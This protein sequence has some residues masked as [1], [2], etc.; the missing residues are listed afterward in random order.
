MNNLVQILLGSI[1]V[2][3]ATILLL[4]WRKRKVLPLIFLGVQI[5]FSVVMCFVFKNATEPIS[6][7][8]AV[9]IYQ[10]YSAVVNEKPNEALELLN[11]SSV[12]TADKMAYTLIK[13]RVYA[14]QGKWEEARILYEKVGKVDDSL[15]QKEE[16]DFVENLTNRKFLTA[17]E[18]SYNVTNANYL[19]SQGQDPEEY[20]FTLFTDE[21][22]QENI[23]YLDKFQKEIVPEIISSE[24]MTMSDDY[25]ILA[26]IDDID[27]LSDMAMAY[28]YK[29]YIGIGTSSFAE[30]DPQLD[31]SDNS[32][33]RKYY[34]KIYNE[35]SE[36]KEKYP[37][38]FVENQ[39]LEAYVMATVRSGNELDDL[40]ED[41]NTN[42]SQT[43]I[44]MYLSGIVN[45][46]NFSEEFAEEYAQ[47]Y[48]AVIDRLHEIEDSLEDEDEDIFIDGK[49]VSDAVEMI[50]DKD[51][52][53]FIKIC[54]ELEHKVENDEVELDKRSDTYLTLAVVENVNG[55]A[56][57]SV[58][59][60]NEAVNS[61]SE[62]SNSS[63][64]NIMSTVEETY[65]DGVS[66]MNY[67]DISNAV[68]EAY[69]S[70]HHYDVVTDEITEN[71]KSTAGTAVSQTLAL[72]SIGRIDT[73]N[74]PQINVSVVYSDDGSLKD[75]GLSMKDCN[76][77]IE[78]YT[79]EKVEHSGSKVVLMCDVSGSMAN[80]I[81][82]LQN[83]VTKYVNNM[84]SGEKVCIV[85][86]DTQVVANS[87]FTS[88]KSK[89]IQFAE[90]EIQQRGGTGVAYSAETALDMFELNDVANT[91][92]IMTDGEDNMPYSDAEIRE[93]LGGKADKNGVTIYTIG[94]GES[95]K[96]T[97]LQTIADAGSG[98]FI[99]C[100]DES[101]LQSAYEFIHMRTNSEYM[102]SFEA[103]DL[104]ST[105]RKYEIEVLDDTSATHPRDSK[106][107]SL[108]GEVEEDDTDVDFDTVL[109]DGVTISGLDINQID[110][111]D[112]AQ[113]I[114]ILGAGFDNVNVQ[115][116]Y[117]SSTEGESNC[118]IKGTEDGKITF[119]VAPSVKEGT[120]SVF[121][122]MNDT[123]YKVDKLVVGSSNPG[124]IVFGAYHFKADNIQAETDKVILSG[125]VSLNDYLYFS[126]N[127]E[128]YG[129]IDKA[130]SI[131]LYSYSSAYVRHDTANYS[132]FDKIILPKTT[133]TKA[134][135]TIKV[136]IFDDANHYNDYEEYETA[137][138]WE[139][140]IAS[141]N[142]GIVSFED[143]QTR[144]YP[145]RV[146]IHSGIGVLKDNTITDL[147]TNG[148]EF[149]QMPDGMPYIKGELDSDS[150]LMK[151]GPFTYF[152]MDIEAGI[153]DEENKC[154]I[155][156]VDYISVE[157][158]AGFKLMYDTYKREFLLG[159]SFDMDNDSEDGSSSSNQTETKCAGT[160][161][162]EISITGE[163]GNERYG[164]KYLNI[165][166]ALP[167]EITFY[168]EGVPVTLTDITASLSDYNITEALNNLISGKAFKNSIRSYLAN[169][170]GA[171]LKVSGAVE[172][173]STAALC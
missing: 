137:L 5:I 19:K 134:F 62:S 110:K 147:M 44:D 26:D 144:I 157:A 56:A 118:K 125:N 29:T 4:I 14:T 126:G 57:Q 170:D 121:V 63:I 135:D 114:N 47:K 75:I 59:Y 148:I 10:I 40:L 37:D 117:L 67:I 2:I 128:L 113:I 61:G 149:F 72:V 168:V 6:N 31:L 21:Q 141:L 132:M 58:K 24:K 103:E 86:F 48:E 11:D 142:L 28:D 162:I 79:I 87:G 116:V 93:K 124:E 22:V 42:V 69:E 129:D 146:Q 83:A 139:G 167:L 45:E 84:A 108:N 8:E 163:E 70:Q 136:E 82:A 32:V 54:D 1:P 109:P 91:L 77:E 65:S 171:N 151:E 169:K 99:Y 155:E 9:D 145:N 12:V 106:E 88:D 76:I 97:Y 52:F 94:L 81:D 13:A 33:A 102:I 104:D 159:V 55:N 36:Y 89:L 66:D 60:F 73:S 112:T 154:G 71:I 80:S 34:G 133:S 111:L 123:K 90:D 27:K 165:D 46:S 49:T 122:K 143:N 98:K 131:E 158:H 3:I 23:Q 64:S 30:E 43:V 150:R 74:F 161:G 17:S 53:P 172:L 25:E 68:S 120:Y 153:N 164:N 7:L 20:G 152:N 96:P 173:V 35:L 39:Y 38:L 16:K 105:T 107:Y 130:P 138:P 41:G 18:L 78:D 51:D 166:L 92:I 100:S 101:A 50:E 156:I 160:A 15:M 127:V 140:E 95:L 119:Q 85:T 115:G